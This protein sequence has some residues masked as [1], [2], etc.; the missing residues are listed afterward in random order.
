MSLFIYC[1]NW[2]VVNIRY[3]HRNRT[4]KAATEIVEYKIRNGGIYMKDMAIQ[5]TTSINHLF[6]NS[7]TTKEQS[8][9]KTLV[10][11][12][13]KDP[14]SA[15]THFIGMV[16]AIGASVPLLIKASRQA[17][18]LYLISMSVY[19]LSL[20]L[21]YAASTTYHTFDRSERINTILKKI[22]HMM[23]SILI[24]GSY[25][26]ICLLVLNKK[27]GIILLSIVWGIALIG[28][29]IKAFWVYCPKWVSSI[30]YIGMG[31]TCV[32][33]FTQIF[34]A[35]SPAGFGWLLIGGIIYTVGGVIYALK[36]PVFNNRHKYFGSHE[37]FHLFV[38]GGSLCHY[39]VMYAYI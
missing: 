24:A 38:M 12:Y 29:L 23:I 33:A 22:D 39:I 31:W 8:T 32:L 9:F 25:T 15:I 4:I 14:G 10:I 11:K 3:F 20:I 35:L 2:K 7:S 27:T 1:F 13:V 19:A 36:L 26:P 21:L 18:P 6:E 30:L 16:M 37:I 28:I 5:T 34:H 17:D